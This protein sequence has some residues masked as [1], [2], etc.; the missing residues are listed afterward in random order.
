MAQHKKQHFVPACYLKAWCDPNAP[1]H[2]TPFVWIF[3]K[4]GSN[5]RRKGPENIFH[6]RDMYTIQTKDGRRNLTLEHGLQELEAQFSR[7]R[8]KKLEQDRPLD[9]TEHFMLC[10]FIAALNFR[11]PAMRE[12][13]REQWERPLRKMEQMME[14]AET[15]TDEEK[16]QAA[17]FLPSSM[18]D[19]GLSYE[20]VKALHKNPTQ[21]MIG[22]VVEMVTPMLAM[23]DMAVFRSSDENLPFITSDHPCVWY[24]SAAYRWPPL[25]RSAELGSK[26]I[27]V[28]LPIS[29]RQIICLNRMR[30]AGYRDASTAVVDEFNRRT[31]FQADKHFVV[32]RNETK[33]FWFDPGVEPEDSWEK[34]RARNKTDNES[35]L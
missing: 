20:E 33:Q 1:R 10:A 34:V 30:V 24:D 14:W 35:S 8:K 7:I 23:L 19:E 12:H 32:N 5:P 26:T 16:R 28:T 21:S 29:P 25:Y 4:D 15:A 22:T 17:V 2:H 11:T 13:H 31:R 9:Q 6:E 18:S 27:E 3:D